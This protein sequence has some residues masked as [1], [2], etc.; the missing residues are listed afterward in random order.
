MQTI[1]IAH[2]IRLVP[3]RTQEDYFNRACGTAR[4]AYNW[5]LAKWKQLYTEGHKPSA[6]MLKKLFR[7]EYPDKFPWVS[8]VTKCAPEQAFSDLATAYNNFFRKQKRYPTFKKKGKSKDSFYLSNDQFRTEGKRIRIPKL[9]WVKMREPLRFRGKVLAARVSR[10]ADQWHVAIQVETQLEP[11]PCENQTEVGIDMGLNCFASLSTGH[12]YYAPKPLKKYL[13]KLNRLQRQLSRKQ[14]GSNNRRKAA[15]KVARLHLKIANIRKDFLHKLTTEIA[16]KYMVVA[17]EDLNVRGMLANRKLSRAISDVGWHE[18]RRQLEYK[19][20]WLGRY[21][22]F[23]D[24]FFPS[25]KTCSVCGCY[26]ENLTLGDRTLNC[27]CGN[28]MDRDLN[29]AI[30]ILKQATEGYSESYA[31]GQ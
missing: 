15:V 3:N 1:A 30:N 21:V 31:C 8:E 19:S 14:K 5:G 20:D 2:K 4:F 18:F 17:L 12:T 16:N 27:D 22:L 25:S 26:F 13:R 24:R 29:A 9:G 6:F 23:V 7:Q 10:S 28:N 11:N